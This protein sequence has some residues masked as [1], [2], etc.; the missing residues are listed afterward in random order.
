MHQYTPHPQSKQLSC[1]CLVCV[2]LIKRM[3]RTK[4]LTQSSEEVMMIKELN[5]TSRRVRIVFMRKGLHRELEFYRCV[6][7]VLA[8]TTTL[9]NFSYIDLGTRAL[10]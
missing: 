7:N 10:I 9:Q 6:T 5:N 1:L 8:A 2:L 4:S 3:V